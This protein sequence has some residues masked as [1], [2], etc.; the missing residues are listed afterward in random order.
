MRQHTLEGL[1]AVDVPGFQTREDELNF[2][3]TCKS[4]FTRP[5]HIAQGPITTPEFG[6]MRDWLYNIGAALALD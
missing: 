5:R 6:S 2:I 3:R 4:H 1:C